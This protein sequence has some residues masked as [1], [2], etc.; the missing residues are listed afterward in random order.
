MI[1]EIEE[2]RANTAGAAEKLAQ[3]VLDVPWSETLLAA[4][5]VYARGESADSIRAI[6]MPHIATCGAHSVVLGHWNRVTIVEDGR[7]IAN[8]QS[9]D[10]HQGQRR[11]R[12][13]LYALAEELGI[14][15]R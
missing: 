2:V 3:L 10:C 11:S 4:A 6:L 8:I 5:C 14:K 13:E 9:G 1:P 15:A 12:G 7:I